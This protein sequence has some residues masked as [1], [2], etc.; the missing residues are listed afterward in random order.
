MS[1]NIKEKVTGAINTTGYPV[2]LSISSTLSDHEHIVWNNKYFF[3]DEIKKARSVDIVSP[4]FAYAIGEVRYGAEIVIECKKSPQTAW[5]FFET[6]TIIQSEYS[7][8]IFDFGKYC[9]GNYDS[10][11]LLWKFKQDLSLHYGPKKGLTQA[12]QNYQVIRIGEEDLDDS[13]RQPKAKDTIF[14]AANQVVKY[15]TYNAKSG[16]RNVLNIFVEK[17]VYPLFNL[18]YPIIVYDGPLYNG[19]L[20]D[21]KIELQE[22]D[23][24]V[25]Q[26]QF[27]PNYFPKPKTFL[28]DVVKKEKFEELLNTLEKEQDS[29]AGHIEAN[30]QDFQNLAKPMHVPSWRF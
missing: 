19:F 1:N 5:V 17:G 18:Y 23:H 27:M 6:P 24:I 10:E 7:G 14:E 13:V 29:I 26:H 20:K 11:S 3:D 28:I 9:K 30:V 25:L 15:I 4:A 16:E 8:Q 2:E 22:R 21:E 12:A